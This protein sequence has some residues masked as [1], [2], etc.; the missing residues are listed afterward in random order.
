MQSE[1]DYYSIFNIVFCLFDSYVRFIVNVITFL[2]FTFVTES[3]NM[4]NVITPFFCQSIKGNVIILRCM[5]IVYKNL[6]FYNSFEKLLWIIFPKLKFT[7]F[8]R[9]PLKTQ[10][11]SLKVTSMVLLSDEDIQFTN[12]NNSIERFVSSWQCNIII[13]V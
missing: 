2:F 9:Q 12:I 10:I 3:E 5:H 1:L 6:C 4:K 13:F 8:Q 7:L 11:K